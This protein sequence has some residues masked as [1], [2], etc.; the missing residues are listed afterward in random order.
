MAL[1]FQQVRIQI[2]AMGENAPA[3]QQILADKRN[4]AW[5]LLQAYQLEVD[6]LR[7]KVQRVASNYDPNLRCARPVDATVRA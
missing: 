2:Q 6:Q 4:K 5:D 3:R 7:S 1:D